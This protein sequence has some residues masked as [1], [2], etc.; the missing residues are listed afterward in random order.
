MYAIIPCER[1]SPHLLI[2]VGANNIFTREVGYNY[3]IYSREL[4]ATAFTREKWIL[5]RWR[6]QHF[7]MTDAVQSLVLV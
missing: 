6:P 7:L 2:R 4:E 1:W 5:E 3:S